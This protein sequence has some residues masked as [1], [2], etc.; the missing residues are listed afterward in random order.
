MEIKNLEQQQE[1]LAQQRMIFAVAAGLSLIANI[2][3]SVALLRQEN[4]VVLIPAQ[5]TH[6]ATVSNKQ[7]DSSYLKQMS[8]FFLANL[9]D[10]TT[11]NIAYHR[12]IV[13]NHLHPDFH[14][15]MHQYFEQENKRYKQYGLSTHFIV[16]ELK[17]DPAKLSVVAIGQLHSQFGSNGKETVHAT[18]HLHYDYK[19]G[20]LL[21][22]GFRLV[23]EQS[24][25]QH[26]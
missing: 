3:L 5:L 11:D 15:E 14:R 9:L 21:L 20:M 24:E 13:L 4:L 25:E 6:E 7:V 23:K 2:T 22:S 18:Y 17:V 12:D 16:N 1:R 26:E 10:L 8:I 19:G